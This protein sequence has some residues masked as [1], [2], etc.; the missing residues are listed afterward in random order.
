[1]DE[2][3]EIR[4]SNQ[5]YEV[6]Y[7]TGREKKATYHNL[8]NPN[9]A[10]LA[11]VLIDLEISTGLPIFQAVKEYIRRRDSKDWLGL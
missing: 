11:A 8:L 10:Q 3:L 1:M 6:N 9:A 5:N 4:K 2:R 7:Y